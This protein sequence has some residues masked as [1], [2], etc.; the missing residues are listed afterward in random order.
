MQQLGAWAE[1]SYQTWVPPN[2]ALF[3]RILVQLPILFSLVQLPIL[4]SLLHLNNKSG[5]NKSK[6]HRTLEILVRIIR[7][8]NIQIMFNYW[9]LL[10]FN[11]NIESKGQVG[12]CIQLHFEWLKSAAGA[13]N[14]VEQILE[15]IGNYYLLITVWLTWR[16]YISLPRLVFYFSY[17]CSSGILSKYRVRDFGM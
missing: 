5:D 14:L 8:Y 12:R 15:S 6:P 16:V 11:V 9:I 17:F 13:W 7:N 3:S 1:D 4:S 10:I 2:F